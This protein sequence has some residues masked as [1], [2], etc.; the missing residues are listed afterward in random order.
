MITSIIM[1]SW[2]PASTGLIFCLL[3]VCTMSRVWWAPRV[4][5]SRSMAH[6]TL[7]FYYVTCYS[8]SRC[9]GAG[10]GSE[11]EQEGKCSVQSVLKCCSELSVLYWRLKATVERCIILN[12]TRLYE[13][14]ASHHWLH[15]HEVLLFVQTMLHA[16]SAAI[17]VGGLNFAV[18]RFFV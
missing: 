2:E 8:H 3:I 14:T 16:I 7:P 6:F 18:W 5:S 11:G 13:D 1:Y 9:E 4:N 10:E 17:F 15:V 12:P